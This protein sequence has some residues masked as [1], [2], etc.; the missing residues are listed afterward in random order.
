MHV[1]S[2]EPSI[3]TFTCKNYLD[4]LLQL[5]IEAFFM[6]YGMQ[7]LN[8]PVA[9]VFDLQICCYS[10]LTHKKTLYRK[11]KNIGRVDIPGISRLE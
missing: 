7:Y 10:C 2:E 5:I 11:A 6:E 1:R 3:I 8:L 4:K 9:Y